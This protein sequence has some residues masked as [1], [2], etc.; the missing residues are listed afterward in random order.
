MSSWRKERPAVHTT[1]HELAE[2]SGAAISRRRRDRVSQGPLGLAGVGARDVGEAGAGARPDL[3]PDIAG[4]LGQRGAL[5]CV[6]RMVT[7]KAAGGLPVPK[8]LS[9]DVYAATIVLLK[10]GDAP[11]ERALA[12]PDGP[13]TQSTSRG[14]TS[15]VTGWSTPCGP[16][17][18]ERW[19]TGLTASAGARI[20]SVGRCSGA[21]KIGVLPPLAITR[22]SG[23]ATP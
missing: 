16:N 21:P 20:S 9:L 3:Q 4:L 10:R 14:A 7:D 19:S 23:D 15:S 13:I 22:R 5:A 1:D 12:G 17:D 2:S 18:L 11:E 6:A 8:E